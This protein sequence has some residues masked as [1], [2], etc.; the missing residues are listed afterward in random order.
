MAGVSMASAAVVR[1][2][3]TD[4]AGEPLAGA[5][6]SLLRQDSTLVD[7]VS[8]NARGAFVMPKV[9]KGKYIVKADYIGGEPVFSDRRVKAAADTLRLP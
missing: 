8:S 7:G 3:V 4:T 9:A 1:G 6:V 2:R 5:T